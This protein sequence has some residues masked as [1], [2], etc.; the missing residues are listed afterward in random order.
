MILTGMIFQYNE[1]E[2]LGLLML[3]DAKQKEFSQK[4]WIDAGNEPAVGQKIAYISKA[5]TFEVR[6]ATQDDIKKS[7]LKQEEQTAEEHLEHF[8]SLG[9]KLVKDTTINNVRT[10]TLRS[11]ANFE[12]EEVII[13]QKD[14]SVSV[15]QSINGKLINE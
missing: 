3:S 8:T 14:N 4:E 2:G 5:D 12:S 15:L 13:T 7:L 10:L 9:F 11:F 6:V 1:E